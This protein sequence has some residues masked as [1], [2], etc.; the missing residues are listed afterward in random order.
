[1]SAFVLLIIYQGLWCFVESRTVARFRPAKLSVSSANNVGLIPGL[2]GIAALAISI[3]SM[4]GTLLHPPQLSSEI[5]VAAGLLCGMSGIFLRCRAIRAL[6]PMFRDSIDLFPNHR[7]IKNGPY[8][9]LKHPAE[10]GFLLA[11]SGLVI[12]SG[13]TPALIVLL[14]VL[15]PLSLLRMILENRML[16]ARFGDAHKAASNLS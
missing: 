11:M 9:F 16:H 12:L 5:I 15:F 13:S 14:L 6:G 1:M 10:T 4:A 8:R 2:T 3:I 7:L